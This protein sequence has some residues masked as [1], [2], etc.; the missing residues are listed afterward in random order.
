MMTAILPIAGSNMF[1]ERASSA[2]RSNIPRIKVW[3]LPGFKVRTN[4]W[5]SQDM[6][7]TGLS[8][9]LTVMKYTQTI[10]LIN[11]AVFTE[12]CASHV[13]C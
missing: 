6:S 7:P 5:S 9:I 1:P 8:R 12:H 11:F 13:M 2:Q 3:S 10:G 4:A